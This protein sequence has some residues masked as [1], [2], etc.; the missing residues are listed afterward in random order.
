MYKTEASASTDTLQ[1]AAV[2]ADFLGKALGNDGIARTAGQQ[3]GEFGL[4]VILKR[5]EFLFCCLQQLQT[6]GSLFLKMHNQKL[7]AKI[8]K[9]Y[10]RICTFF[11]LSSD[12]VSNILKLGRFCRVK[13]TR[14]IFDIMFHTHSSMITMTTKSI[15]LLMDQV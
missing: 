13:L 4:N 14:I 7:K 9:C 3:A 2:M 12:R 1:T 6:S 10:E 8:L 5:E 11:F 15:T